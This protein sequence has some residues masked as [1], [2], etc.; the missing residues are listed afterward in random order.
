MEGVI[1]VLMNPVAIFAILFFAFG[2]KNLIT[3]HIPSAVV[4]FALSLSIT[5]AGAWFFGKVATAHGPKE[6]TLGKQNE[7]ASNQA[8]QAIGASAPQPER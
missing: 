1:Y 4:Y 2:I 8:S 5:L 3:R 7:R 6:V